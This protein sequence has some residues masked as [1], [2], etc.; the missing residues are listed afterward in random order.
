[1]LFHEIF[2]IFLITHYLT[3][4]SYLLTVLFFTVQAVFFLP[5]YS[6]PSIS[7][8]LQPVYTSPFCLLIPKPVIFSHPNRFLTPIIL[9]HAAR[10]YVNRFIL[11]CSRRF[12][13]SGLFFTVQPGI[14]S[15]GLQIP[16]RFLLCY[17]AAYSLLPFT[18]LIFLAERI[19]NITVI[20]I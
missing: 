11:H 2:D 4:Q 3:T 19:I 15:P 1:M 18:G 17:V 5:A 20:A 7:V 14:P 9:H 16:S 8:F 12:L 6:L 10:S 13:S